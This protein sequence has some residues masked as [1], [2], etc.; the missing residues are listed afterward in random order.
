MCRKVVGDGK[1][2]DDPRLQP[3]DRVIALEIYDPS[4]LIHYVRQSSLKE[5]V[6][7]LEGS[8]KTQSSPTCFKLGT[9]HQ[10]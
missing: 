5:F 10:F 6:H 1:D 9:C 2:L 4:S 7:V 3:S 8:S